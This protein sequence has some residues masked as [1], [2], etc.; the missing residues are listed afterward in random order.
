MPVKQGVKITI[1]IIFKKKSSKKTA[2]TTTIYSIF[3][4]F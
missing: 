1:A 3:D 2:L 4:K